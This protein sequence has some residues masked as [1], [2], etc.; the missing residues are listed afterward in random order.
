VDRRTILKAIGWG[1]GA[2]ALPH[3]VAC[4]TG[5]RLG[6]GPWKGPPVGLG[7]ARL[8]ALSY[9]MLAPNAHNT[10]PWLVALGEHSIDLF[11]DGAR[12][13]PETDPPYRQTHVSQGTFLE[14][15][16]IAL[17]EE[18]MASDVE[19]FPEGEY[20]ND[21]LEPRPVARVHLVDRAPA[22]DSLFS[23]ITERRS[24]KS[25]YDGRRTLTKSEV[26]SLSDVTRESIASLSIID[27]ADARARLADICT[28][29]MAVEVSAVPRNAE[30]ARWFRFSEG[31]S[32]E[33]RDGFGIAQTGRGKVER[34][35]AEHL[36]LDRATA[37]DPK[38]SFA[39]GAVDMTREQAASAAAFGLLSTQGN[40]RRS[41]IVAGR[42]YARIAL[43]T[44]SLGLAMHPMSQALE[45]YPDMAVTK[46]RLEKEVGLAEDCT[47]QMLFRLGHAEPTEH[48]PRR[49]VRALLKAT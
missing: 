32:E 37:S 12:L 17:S 4:R 28:E 8:R 9:A 47:V 22:K 25:V 26:R 41:Q 24:N 42:A 35:F 7:D 19:Y 36:V 38:G 20:S 2:V 29:A 11:V 33:K 43:T 14:L 46:A 21:V 45:E 13:L 48:T 16:V 3:V 40:T 18:G 30:T 34:W 10:Q 1:A 15:L 27:A 49:D 6:L 23:A 39:R 31:E 44:T 5:V